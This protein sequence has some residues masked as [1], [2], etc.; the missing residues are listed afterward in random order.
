MALAVM[1]LAVEKQAA[2]SYILDLRITRDDG[3]RILCDGNK[4]KAMLERRPAG[5]PFDAERVQTLLDN[6]KLWG[7]GPACK[8]PPNPFVSRDAACDA[9][10]DTP[11]NVQ[12]TFDALRKK[13]AVCELDEN[14]GSSTNYPG[15]KWSNTNVI[16]TLIKWAQRCVPDSS[17]AYAERV[18]NVKHG[19]VSASIIDH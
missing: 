1:K 7:S 17:K 14:F 6:D 5:V 12:L 19:R 18:R 9:T 2:R 3:S 11:L 16:A 8:P 10:Y 13:H 15:I 4:N